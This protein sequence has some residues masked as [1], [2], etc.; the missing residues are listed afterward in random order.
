MA[1]HTKI[2]EIVARVVGQVLE[3]HIPHLREELVRRVLEDLPET[4]TPAGENGAGSQAVLESL[5][6]I[7]KGTAQKEILKQLLEQTAGYCGRAALFIVKAGTV[8][9]WQARGFANNDQIKSFTLQA[10][11]DLV[12][13]VVENREAAGGSVAQMG[14]QFAS[15]FDAPSDGDCFLLPL[16]L[17]EKVAA[18][19][20]ADA[21]SELAGVLDQAALELM[22]RATGQWLEVLALRKS[23]VPAGAAE[24][25]VAE[26]VS[27]AAEAVI[28]TPAPAQ[29]MAAAAS[30]PQGAKA[31]TSAPPASAAAERTAAPSTAPAAP[32]APDPNDIQ[33]KAQRFA[34]LLIDE[35]KLYNLAKVEEGRKH[36]D[37]YDRLK[38]DIEKSRTTYEKRYS[39]TPA[40]SGD[41]F[42][43]ELVRSL[44]QDDPSL[45]GRNYRR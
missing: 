42:Y 35:I 6:T 33:V 34:R 40:S 21:G 11:A 7:Q 2:Q 45:L 8:Q 5:V 10:S 15:T 13:L 19:V 12:K 14:D 25:P 39:N 24:V 38:D 37:L 17:K 3:S 30:A 23:P 27:S 31:A 44:A 16:I 36:R 1:D 29:T 43:H 32:A 26:A 22:V 4:P 41:Y 18:L 28:E 9:G 20:Y